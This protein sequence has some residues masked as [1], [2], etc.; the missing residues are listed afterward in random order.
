MPT[1]NEVTHKQGVVVLMV[2]RLIFHLNL[3]WEYVFTE[4]RYN[5]VCLLHLDFRLNND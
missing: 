3:W 4:W 2:E 1:T 5:V